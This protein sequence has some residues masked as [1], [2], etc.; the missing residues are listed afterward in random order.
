MVLRFGKPWRWSMLHYVHSKVAARE[1]GV[2]RAFVA[3]A[4]MERR[5]L[6]FAEAPDSTPSALS[7]RKAQRFKENA[8]HALHLA[9]QDLSAI[10]NRLAAQPNSFDDLEAVFA[11]WFLILHFG[12]YDVDLVHTSYMHLAGIRA[13]LT[14]WFHGPIERRVH[15]LPAAAKQL[16]LFIW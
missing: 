5:C 12:I 14:D 16:L 7:L 6:E 8:S 1:N 3:V 15:A 11:L 4:S 13:F 2:L 9:M 10:I